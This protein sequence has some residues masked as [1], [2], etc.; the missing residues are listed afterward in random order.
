MWK[1]YLFRL[2]WSVAYFMPSISILCK[3]VHTNFTTCYSL[4]IQVNNNCSNLQ[5][6]LIT[7]ILFTTQDTWVYVYQWKRNKR[8]KD[9]L[10]FRQQCFLWW[11]ER[12]LLNDLIG[13]VVRSYI[14]Y[15]S[16]AVGH[17]IKSC[18]VIKAS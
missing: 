9:Q 1:L 10:C 13:D 5:S 18:E 14:T 4:V 11:F 17:V 3:N 8:P 15:S 7:M 16:G 12:S 2:Q 6:M